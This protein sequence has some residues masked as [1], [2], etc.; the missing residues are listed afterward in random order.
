MSLAQ[1]KPQEGANAHEPSMDEILA[2]IRKII[3][4]EQTV[5]P[6]STPVP[7]AKAAPAL[8]VAAPLQPVRAA[9]GPAHNHDDDVLDLADVTIST[10]GQVSVDANDLDFRTAIDEEPAPAPVVPETPPPAPPAPIVNATQMF[11]APLPVV[12]APIPAPV[13][14]SPPPAAP[15]S[16]PAAE[17]PSLLSHQTDAAVSSAFH[18]LSNTFL[19]QNARTLDDLV[20]D[21]LRPMLK[22]WLDDNLPTLVERLV[23]AEIERVAR[24]GR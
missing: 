13:A 12:E 7:V 19:S 23:R 17:A 6:A 2:S 24:G 16:L 8:P 14:V 9:P 4:D 18:S 1:T 3:A 15:A 21:M 11:H 20:K 22:S 10:P 5:K